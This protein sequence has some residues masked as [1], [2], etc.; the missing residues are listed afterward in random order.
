MQNSV[1]VLFVLPLLLGLLATLP[2]YFG[3]RAEYNRTKKLVDSEQEKIRA[4]ADSISISTMTTI[5]E[6]LRCEL[7]DSVKRFQ[8][9]LSDLQIEYQEDLKKMEVRLNKKVSQQD[10]EIDR[11]TTGINL[12]ID[13]IEDLGYLPVWRP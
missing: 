7:N 12:L 6:N 1:W 5:I 9:N 4:E 3:S 11:L 13:Q 8:K 10:K 2:G